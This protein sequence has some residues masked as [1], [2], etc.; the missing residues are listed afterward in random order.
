LAELQNRTGADRAPSAPA[1]HPRGAGATALE[2]ARLDVREA[3]YCVLCDQIVERTQDGGCP[4]GHPA[5]G[6]TGRI[7]L[8]DDDPVPQLPAFNWA[9]FVLPFIWGPAHEQWIGAIFLPI[10]LFA[11]SIIGT[12]SKGGVVGE[13]AAT[14]VFALTLLFQWWFAKRANGLAFRQ[15]IGRLSAER[16]VRRQRIWTIVSV[17][18]AAVLVTWA[19]WFHFVVAPTFVAR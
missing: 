19:V 12:A 18:V 1:P 13:L 9:A 16:F 17:P 14:A 5:D 15:V 11:D 4:Q 6:I 7:V 10:W 3:G 2:E 8:I